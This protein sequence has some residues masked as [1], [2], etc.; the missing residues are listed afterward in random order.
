MT[1][2]SK[3]ILELWELVRHDIPAS[4]RASVAHSMMALF[5]EY[6]FEARD[7]ADVVE[8]DHVLGKAYF[9]VFEG[10]D[11]QELEDDDYYN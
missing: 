9:E 6:G 8:E 4:S 3:L 1:S 2:E 11:D 7:V 5:Y 10:E